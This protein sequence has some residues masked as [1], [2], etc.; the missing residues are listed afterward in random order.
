M[1]AG[2]LRSSVTIEQRGTVT[3][4][5]SGAVSYQW[6]EVATVRADVNQ[7]GGTEQAAPDGF[8]RTAPY[9]IRIRYRTDLTTDM[10]L[11]F[12]G[13]KLEILAINNIDQMNRWLE[14]TAQEGLSHGN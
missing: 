8:Q 5:E 11:D 7:V 13:K 10:R 1:R 2:K 3:R 4:S 9:R 12:G 6:P 14:I